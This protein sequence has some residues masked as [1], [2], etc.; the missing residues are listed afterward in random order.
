MRRSFIRL[1]LVSVLAT[2][3]VGFTVLF[4][5]TYTLRWAEDRAQH[6]GIFLIHD[7]LT[8]TPVEQ[9]ERRLAELQV[10]TYVPLSLMS[11]GDVAAK[12][13]REIEGAQAVPLRLSRSEEWYFLGFEDDSAVLAAGPVNPWFPTST[14]PIGVVLA[15]LF[16]PIIAGIVT[17]QMERALAK[18]ERASDALAVGE[19]GA[20]VE[21]PR[22]PSV[23]LAARFNA[24]AERIEELVRSRD[25]LV[26]AVSHELGSPLS[27]LRFHV[28]LLERDPE[29]DREQRL[30]NMTR[31]LD[32]LEE[33]VAE[34]LGYVQS[35]DLR[36]EPVAFDPAKVLADLVE[37]SVLEASDPRDV[38]VELV[39]PP[40]LEVFAD[41]R[42]FQR[43]VENL[44]RNAI[45][46]ADK[47]VRLELSRVVAGVQVA[48][49]DD[50]PG[51]PREMRDKV[52]MP[53]VRL[54]EDRSRR[55]GG[56]GL[57]LAIVRRIVLRHGGR[58]EIHES[59]LGGALV[60]ILWPATL[61]SQRNK[62]QRNAAS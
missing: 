50:G 47:K 27:R 33:L 52:V 55:T 35:S 58:L 38:S 28:E 57:G 16:G 62:S 51:I 24:M 46:Y 42:L 26:Q 54:D 6:S 8:S 4:G 59:T 19:L 36:V 34:L 3:V 22:G 56:V 32:A 44:L 60:T 2:W 61:P 12:L 30:A 5:Y 15:I 11:R 17:L 41:Q 43:A 25:E 29:A 13:G 9:R 39:V 1:F 18:V 7:L 37:L 40:G 49:H 14:F 48:V 20:R 53:F 10:H 31:E 23:E 21:D 45:R